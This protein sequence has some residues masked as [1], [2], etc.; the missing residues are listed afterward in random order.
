MPRILVIGAG[1]QIGSELTYK[2]RELYGP[3]N[4]VASDIGYH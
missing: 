4:V 1:G 3:E 2:L